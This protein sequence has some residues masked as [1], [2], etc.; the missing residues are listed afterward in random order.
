MSE[1]H[2]GINL[3]DRPGERIDTS[4]LYPTQLRPFQLNPHH[5]VQLTTAMSL[6]HH[7]IKPPKDS[8]TF[9]IA[10][11]RCSTCI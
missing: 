3:E 8:P 7:K 4:M 10:Q 6:N 9:L 5:H 2:E 1:P 11:G